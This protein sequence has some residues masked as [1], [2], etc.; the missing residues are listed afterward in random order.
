MTEPTNYYS[1]FIV[2]SLIVLIVYYC[3]YSYLPSYTTVLIAI[4]TSSCLI[5]RPPLVH[6]LRSC[7]PPTTSS[8]PCHL[9]AITTFLVYRSCCLVCPSKNTVSHSWYSLSIHAIFVCHC[10][11]TTRNCPRHSRP[12]DFSPT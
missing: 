3:L 11:V 9:S 4:S 6:P 2:Y 12:F 1:S 10:F 5:H 8:C 7:R